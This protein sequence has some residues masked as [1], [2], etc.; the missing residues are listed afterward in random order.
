MIILLE[1]G[2]YLEVTLE[3]IKRNC[4][5]ALTVITTDS[6]DAFMDEN[7]HLTDPVFFIRGSSIKIINCEFEKQVHTLIQKNVEYFSVAKQFPGAYYS[8]SFHKAYELSGVTDYNTI[9]DKDVMLVN[10]QNYVKHRNGNIWEMK[11]SSKVSLLPYSLNAKDDFL[12]TQIMEPYFM[13]KK[14]IWFHCNTGLLNFSLEII[15]SNEI[16]SYVLMPFDL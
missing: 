3:S 5:S 14:N 4:S 2:K 12:M 8:K 16:D 6:V 11:K 10:P 7:S 1:E 9:F 15:N 13:L